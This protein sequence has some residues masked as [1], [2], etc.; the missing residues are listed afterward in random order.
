M[1]K[2]LSTLSLFSCLWASAQLHIDF[3]VANQTNQVFGLLN[4]DNIPHNMLLDYGYDFVDVPNYDGVLRDNNYVV[5]SVYRTLYNSVVSMR[6]QLA[7]PELVDP[8]SL[9]QSWK[10]TAKTEANKLGKG[11]WATAVAVNGLYYHYS[12]IREDALEQGLIEVVDGKQYR[13]VYENTQWKNPYETLEVFAMSLPFTRV[14]NPK[15]SLVL[16]E[17]DW[18]TNQAALVSG[19]AVDFGDGSGFQTLQMGMSLAHEFKEDGDYVWTFRIKLTNGTFKY[20][21]TPVKVTGKAKQQTLTSKNP[22]CAGKIHE[23]PINATQ[24]FK[25]STGS[26]T[27]Q[28]STTDKSCNLVIRKPLIVVEGFDSGLLGNNQNPGDTHLNTFLRDVGEDSNSQELKNL[29]TENTEESF[30]IIYVNWDHGTD[31]LQRNAFV[32][33]EVIRWVNTIKEDDAAPN[34]V[35][36]QSMGGVLARYALRN[37]ENHN[38]DHD[39]SLYISHDAPHQ[40]A[41]VPPG[42]LYLVRHALNELITTPIGDIAVAAASGHFPVHEARELIDQ[43]AVKQLLINY[44]D[45]NYEIDNAEHMA[46]QSE[47]KTMGYP[48]LTKNI[49]LGNGSHC[50]QPYGIA[51]GQ[52]L[53]RLNGSA[54]TRAL[55]DIIMFLFPITGVMLGIGLGDVEIA[56]LGLLPGQTKLKTDFQVWAVPGGDDG[57]VYKGWMQYEK[58]FLWV[59][60]L[61][62]TITNQTF[63]WP[64]EQLLLSDMPGGSMPFISSIEEKEK[65]KENVFLAYGFNLDITHDINFIPTTS[66][67][68]VGGGNTTLVEADYLRMYTVDTQLPP[69]LA[70]PFDNFATTYDISG[71]NAPHISFNRSSG[72]WLA[73]ELKEESVPFDCTFLCTSVAEIVGNDLLCDEELYYV[74]VLGNAQFHWSSS[75]PDVAAPTDPEAPATYFA[76]PPNTYSQQVII[77]VTISSDACEGEP[78]VVQKELQVGRPGEPSQLFGPEEVL[79]GALVNYTGGPAVGAD[80]YVWWLPYPFEVVDQFDLFGDN[81]QIYSSNT[82]Y[83]TAEVFTGYAKNEGYVQLMGVNDCGKGPPKKLYVK[84]SGEGDDPEDGG[85]GIPL[86]QDP[87]LVW[88]TTSNETNETI[89]M[90]PNVASEHV[91]IGVVG[92]AWSQGE[93]TPRILGVTVYVQFQPI[94]K[95]SMDFAYP[96]VTSATLDIQDLST[97]YYVVAIATTRGPVNKI[98]IV[99]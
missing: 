97:G 7:V 14:D 16:D 43:P 74:D 6:T 59:A 83:D 5:P 78:I 25:G 50:A 93:K 12:R 33:E 15:V 24:S 75:N 28:I 84:H 35:L 34:V 66:A 63:S 60:P 64:G 22:E 29:I 49:A 86:Q 81:W 90:Y 10:T 41:H 77:T 57:W 54:S 87:E 9:E 27:L 44:V 61:M 80:S 30:D 96:G 8:V 42:F 58:K 55:S 72:D 48:Q 40:G 1:K 95:K 13:D 99:D 88:N 11:A 2:L 47:L 21:R 89:A 17:A 98:L 91:N 26:A 18:Y 31:W 39:T 36:G 19:F 4:K 70:I 71:A 65:F 67:L 92:S 46:W 76:T 56:L 85:G 23:W 51:P 3:E 79:T 73:K 82:N 53:F 52:S 68:D 45:Q 37:M 69:E 20:C 62:Q 32:L 94:V 38:E